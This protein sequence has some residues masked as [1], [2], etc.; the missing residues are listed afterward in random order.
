MPPIH[1]ETPG[2]NNTLPTVTSTV[3]KA[4]NTLEHFTM[5]R[6][7]ALRAHTSQRGAAVVVTV[8]CVMPPVSQDPEWNRV[9]GRTFAGPGFEGRNEEG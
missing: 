3:D 2:S 9:S 6:S 4:D 7:S 8:T 5:R 1:A